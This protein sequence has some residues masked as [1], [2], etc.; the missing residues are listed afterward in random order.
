MLTAGALRL[1]HPGRRRSAST[2]ATSSRRSPGTRTI[3]GAAD[4]AIDVSAVR[5]LVL[6]ATGQ[7]V[8]EA[9]SGDDQ[10]AA[11]IQPDQ[12]LV[13]RRGADPDDAVERAAIQLAGP[14]EAATWSG[15]HAAH[16]PPAG[17]PSARPTRP[18]LPTTSRAFRCRSPATIAA[19]RHG[20]PTFSALDRVC[21]ES[22]PPGQGTCRGDSGGGL[23][24]RGRGRQPPRRPPRR[25]DQLRPRQ[26]RLGADD[27][28]PG[29]RRPDPKR[30]RRRPRPRRD[31]LGL[32]P[33]GAARD[34]DHQ[35]PEAQ[36][37][38]AEGELQVRRQR[39]GRLLQV[40]ARRPPGEAL[41]A[42]ARGRRSPAAATS[43]RSGP[44]TRSASRTRRR[45]GT[46]GG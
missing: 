8:L 20:R 31:R 7:P 2:R 1:R 24:V 16:S 12:L 10:G 38:Q 22:V 14:D 3:S 21:A 13:G 9:R 15:G 17:A 23:V 45:P 41:R 11:A 27:V 32:A 37:P 40:Q 34:T 30:A 46:S 25:A 44:S 35:A 36:V 29:R 28:R 19:G 5:Y 26:L 39:A 43:S 6:G 4:T 33:A 42:E 18:S